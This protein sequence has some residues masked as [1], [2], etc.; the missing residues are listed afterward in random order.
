MKEL[1][2]KGYLNGDF[3]SSLIAQQKTKPVCE[4]Y[5]IKGG[6]KFTQKYKPL[7]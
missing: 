5:I 1:F 2:F 6:M 4:A 7:L 3:S